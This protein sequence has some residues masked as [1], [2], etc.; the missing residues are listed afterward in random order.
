MRGKAGRGRPCRNL[1]GITPAHAGKS[2]TRVRPRARSKDHPRP[3][4]EKMRFRSFQVG[5]AGSPPPMRGKVPDGDKPST[6][7]RIT[8]A[9]A[10]KRSPLWATGCSPEDHPRPCGEKRCVVLRHV[11]AQ[12]SPP[13]MRGKVQQREQV[14]LAAGITPAHAG[15]RRHDAAY[16]WYVPQTTDNQKGWCKYYAANTRS[17]S[18]GVR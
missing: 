3:C 6:S 9:H 5:R 1:V 17:N 11:R 14:A 16:R 7:A 12:G 4:G 15:K 18:T 2:S 8:P 10:G 13:P